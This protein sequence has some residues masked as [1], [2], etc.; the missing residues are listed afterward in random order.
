MYIQS[1]IITKTI[2]SP[3]IRKNWPTYYYEFTWT[4]GYIY[5]EMST[6]W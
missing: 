4:Y 3:I 2:Q 1:P 6:E 5:V